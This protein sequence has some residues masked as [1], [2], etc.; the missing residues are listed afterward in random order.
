LKDKEANTATEDNEEEYDTDTKDTHRERNKTM[1]Y[2]LFSSGLKRPRSS[3]DEK[4][5][6]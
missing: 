5:Q 6:E 4:E 2:P 3:K 1:P